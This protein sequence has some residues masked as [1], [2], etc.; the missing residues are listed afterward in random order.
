MS[1]LDWSADDRVCVCLKLKLIFIDIHR[2]ERL[3]KKQLPEIHSLL[4]LIQVQL[5]PLPL[6]A[7]WMSLVFFDFLLS[8]QEMRYM[9]SAKRGKNPPKR[10]LKPG[11]VRLEFDLSL[12]LN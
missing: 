6:T 9:T 7:T 12:F 1:A 10:S 4:I 2:Q 3:Q 11:K 5:S 8:S